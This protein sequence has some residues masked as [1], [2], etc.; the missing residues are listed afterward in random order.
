MMFDENQAIGRG[1]S[2]EVYEWKEGRVLK[3]FIDSWTAEKVEREA[4]TMA[5]VRE[6]GL[7]VPVVD[8]IEEIDGRLGIVMEKIQGEVL[9]DMFL[10]KPWSAVRHARIMAEVH[11]QMHSC[12][13]LKLPSFHEYLEHRIA[14]TSV[15]S[16]DMKKE[17]LGLLARL[18]DGD[19]V[20]HGDF[21]IGNVMLTSDE[22]VTI[23][24]YAS[25]RGN[26]LADVARTWML[27]GLATWP[28]GF[29]KR[30]AI[31]PLRAFFNRAYLNR[32]LQLRPTSREEIEQWLIPI[33]AA[34][35]AENVAGEKERFPLIIEK[36]LR[37]L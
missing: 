21:Y 7:R 10:S 13:V 19:T 36:L 37:R 28:F 34:R 25:G 5:K 24:W 33:L 12:E 17:V 9:G 2:A 4:A 18:P 3:L 20:C 23:D 27:H 32:Y 14:S 6:A 29:P 15:L 30:L 1:R 26:P 35:L 22:P 31:D 16:P 8:G 11:A